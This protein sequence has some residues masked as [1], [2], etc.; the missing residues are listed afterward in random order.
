MLIVFR[1]DWWVIPIMLSIYFSYDSLAQIPKAMKSFLNHI[2]D[3][4]RLYVYDNENINY[5][6]C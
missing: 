5:F 1:V 3:L 4:F 6:S 2:V